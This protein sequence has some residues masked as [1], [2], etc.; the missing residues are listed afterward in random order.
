MGL[1]KTRNGEWGTAS[2]KRGVG[3]GEW[4]T[5]SGKRGVGN[6]GWETL[7]GERGVGNEHREPENYF[8]N[9]NKA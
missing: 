9:G 4:G 6:G 2:G 7:S 8:K 5:A 3:N 1:T